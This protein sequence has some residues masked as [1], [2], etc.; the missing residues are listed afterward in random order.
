M[1]NID[2]RRKKYRSHSI[3]STCVG[4]G[5]KS[6]FWQWFSIKPSTYDKRLVDSLKIHC[7]MIEPHSVFIE[8]FSIVPVRIWETI[9][10]AEITF[11]FRSRVMVRKL[12]TTTFFSNM[13]RRAL[14]ISRNK[15]DQQTILSRQVNSS[16]GYTAL[17]LRL[18]IA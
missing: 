11:W 14:E 10:S 4:G 5:F 2:Y 18:R 6:H 7:V 13:L 17:Y 15:K 12:K 1:P 3:W 16:W 9:V 8:S